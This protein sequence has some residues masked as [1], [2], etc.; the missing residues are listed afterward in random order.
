MKIGT[1][2]YLGLYS[3]DFTY[4]DS[5]QEN[6]ITVEKS[7][8]TSVKLINF[9]KHRRNF[10][11]LAQIKLFQA[12]TDAY[13]TLRPVEYFKDCFDSVHTYNE[14]D[15][16]GCF[17][18]STLSRTAL[19]DF[20]W[21]RSYQIEPRQ[22]IDSVDYQQRKSQEDLTASHRSERLQA[23]VK[24]RSPAVHSSVDCFVLDRFSSQLSIESILQNNQQTTDNT[25]SV[26]SVR[27]SPSLPSLDKMSINSGQSFPQRQESREP[28]DKVRRMIIEKENLVNKTLRFDRE[29]IRDHHPRRPVLFPV[30]IISL[31][32]LLQRR[33]WLMALLT[34][35]IM[36]ESE[37]KFGF[38]AEAIS[39]TKR[40]T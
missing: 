36:T 29:P 7:D 17:G 9:E 10:D 26:D 27:S 16:Y 3:S 18:G 6:Y 12:A 20:S 23:Y 15:R 37:R 1:I 38:M 8:K 21:N 25:A 13:S 32:I 39:S 4:I 40:S 22:T 11:V 28:S 24:R 14:V 2:P 19:F 33:V 35:L 5:A 30:K 31:P 34:P